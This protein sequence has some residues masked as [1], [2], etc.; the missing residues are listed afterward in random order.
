MTIA[1]ASFE[2]HN[3]RAGKRGGAGNAGEPLG[4]VVPLQQPR[5]R[6]GRWEGEGRSRGMFRGVAESV[7][8]GRVAARGVRYA[9][10]AWHQF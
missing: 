2:V 9:G 5:P 8:P 6:R 3:A 1:K 7:G 4:L 10:C